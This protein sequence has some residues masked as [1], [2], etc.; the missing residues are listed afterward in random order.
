MDVI[1]ALMSE[2]EERNNVS[3]SITLFSDGSGDVSEFWEEESIIE[4]KN[5]HEL[6][7]FLG[8][9]KYKLSED[10]RCLSPM[11]RIN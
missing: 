4:F 7:G 11:Q 3:I 1:L 5:K 2:F 8:M 6:V 9:A 10:G